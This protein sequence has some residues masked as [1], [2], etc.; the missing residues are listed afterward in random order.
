MGSEN[1]YYI[2]RFS[3]KLGPFSVNELSSQRI[4]KN[5]LIW[6]K[7]LEN[8]KTAS[9][10]PELNDLLLNLPPSLNY[11]SIISMWFSNVVDLLIVPF[12]RLKSKVNSNPMLKDGLLFFFGCSGLLVLF[13]IPFLLFPFDN[14]IL[15]YLGIGQIFFGIQSIKTNTRVLA[16]ILGI[17][18]GLICLFG[19]FGN[20]F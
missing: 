12:S 20:N 2:H 11:I 4:R 8:W 5:T 3:K 17:I 7:G 19:S 1:K 16:G 18:F 10:I 6:Y 15:F 14:I 13:I 9:E